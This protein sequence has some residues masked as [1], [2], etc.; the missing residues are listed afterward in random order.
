MSVAMRI[1]IEQELL[2]IEA[3]ECGGCRIGCTHLHTYACDKKLITYYDTMVHC[4][5]CD[6]MY[7][8]LMFRDCPICDPRRY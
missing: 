6:H 3:G 8:G 1:D 5:K 4:R 7:P 2:A